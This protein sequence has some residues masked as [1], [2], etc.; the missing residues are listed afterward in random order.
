M[1]DIVQQG[2]PITSADPPNN[3]PLVN[4]T[5][6]NLDSSEITT[7]EPTVSEI[8]TPE[9]TVSEITTPEPTV[10]EITTPEPTVPE[11]TTPEP[12]VPEITKFYVEIDL[13][14]PNVPKVKFT[15]SNKIDKID[16]SNW[17]DIDVPVKGGRVTKK[18]KNAIRK[19]VH[20]K[21]PRNSTSKK[22]TSTKK[23]QPKVR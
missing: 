1:S 17:T 4:N 23:R 10:S 2:G 5:E 6:S 21:K 7:P 12:T 3:T 8:T 9:P 11:I 19:T 16:T 15:G 14:T 22:H 18:R 20:R 13:E